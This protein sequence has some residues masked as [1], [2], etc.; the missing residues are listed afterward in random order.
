MKSIRLYLDLRYL[1]CHGDVKKAFQPKFPDKM[2]VSGTTKGSNLGEIHRTHEKVALPQWTGD[3]IYPVW[4]E[5][6]DFIPTEENQATWFING[7]SHRKS[8]DTK[9]SCGGMNKWS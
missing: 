9:H 1:P 7:N 8:Q 6:H 2:K 5:P 4:C 3:R